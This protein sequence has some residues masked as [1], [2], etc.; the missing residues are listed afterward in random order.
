MSR[1]SQARTPCG[2]QPL[3]PNGACLLGSFNLVKYV[4]DKVFDIDQF[5]DDIA[6]VVRAMDNVIDRTI[7]PLEAQRIE[8]QQ[9]RRMGLGVTGLA[10]AGEMLGLPYA[11]EPSW[12]GLRWYCRHYVTTPTI[13]AATWHKREGPFPLWNHEDYSNSAFIKTLPQWLQD[14]VSVYGTRNSHLLSIAPTGTISLTADNVS[15]GIEPPFS[16]YYDRTIQQFD[17]HQVRA[18][19]GLCVSPGCG[20][21]DS[22]RDHG[23]R[24][25]R[26][27]DLG[28][29]VCR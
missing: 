5:I 15:S 20:R 18:C 19:R 25:R 1:R 13:R 9:K 2:E 17:G 28:I 21:Q 14:E 22:Q 11:L 3:P 12:N 26:C 8:A 24:T 6:V 16:L 10:N 4:E 23:R 27:P 29:Q 7:Y